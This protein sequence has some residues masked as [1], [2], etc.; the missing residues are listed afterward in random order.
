MIIPNKTNWYDIVPEPA[1]KLTYLTF[2][3][4][5]HYRAKLILK[6]TVPSTFILEENVVTTPWYMMLRRYLP[7]TEAFKQ[8]IDEM[9]SNG[10]IQ[11]RHASHWKIEKDK[12]R[13][14]E[15]AEPQI[16]SVFDLR[17]G[18]LG[19]LICLA[20]SFVVFLIELIKNH[21]KYQISIKN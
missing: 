19:F 16:L 10:M 5:Y 20:I 9:L 2:R 18:F 21:Q 6:E 8:K 14:V 15:E 17:L 11:K 4:H 7:Y 3:A 12:K 1:N 13:Y